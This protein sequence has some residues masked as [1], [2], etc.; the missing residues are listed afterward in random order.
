MG[1]FVAY[2]VCE[3]GSS[4]SNGAD[5]Y[6]DQSEGGLDDVLLENVKGGEMSVRSQNFSN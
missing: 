1:A 2:F 3:I 5:N 6:Y 4:S